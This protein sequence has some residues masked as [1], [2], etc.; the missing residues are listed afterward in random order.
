MFERDLDTTARRRGRMLPRWQMLI[1]HGADVQERYNESWT[2]LRLAA[3]ANADATAEML[4]QH[5]ADVQ[6][7]Y[8]EGWT[9]LRLAA[10]AMLTRRLRC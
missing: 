9:P 5:G 10:V 2:P 7:R 8:N 1:Q 6:E 3:V 4:I